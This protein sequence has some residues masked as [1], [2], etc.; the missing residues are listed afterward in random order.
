MISVPMVLFQYVDYYMYFAYMFG[1]MLIL[2]IQC[3]FVLLRL[4]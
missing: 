4:A 2:P 3:L 1:V